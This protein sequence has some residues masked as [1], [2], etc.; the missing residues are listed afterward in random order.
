MDQFQKREQ[1]TREKS[2]SYSLCFRRMVTRAEKGLD[3]TGDRLHETPSK[4][5][6]N[7]NG[8]RYIIAYTVNHTV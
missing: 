6:S 5:Y 8:K 4:L 2:S 3:E 1:I 7:L